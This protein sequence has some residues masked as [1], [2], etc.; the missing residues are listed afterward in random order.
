MGR[1]ARYDEIADHY[2]SVVGDD[3]SDSVAATLLELIGPLREARVL[4]LACGQGRVS[5]ELARRGATVVGVDLSTRLLDKARAAEQNEPLGISYFHADA[6]SPGALA[7]EVFDGVVCHF[8]LSDIDDLGGV[9]ATVSRVLASRGWFAFSIVHPCFPG[10]GDEAPSSWPPG[11]GYYTEGWW[12][13]GSPGFRGKVGA[14]H[15]TLSTYVNQLVEHGLALEQV[16]EPKP[17]EEWVSSKPSHDPVPV[18]LVVRC[19]KPA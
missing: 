14:N 2:D 4:D 16:A 17:D 19:R 5:R 8:G 7:D 13:A 6:T 15:R 12:L 3:V 1:V 18:Y 11:R 10:V 9:L